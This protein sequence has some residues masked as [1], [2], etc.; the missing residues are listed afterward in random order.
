[1]TKTA[2]K[3]YPLGSYIPIAHITEYP[4]GVRY[5]EANEVY[6]YKIVKVMNFARTQYTAS[7]SL[8]FVSIF[9]R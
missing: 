9:P 2:E 7:S 1:M 6:V 3:P 8:S 4:P 5:S